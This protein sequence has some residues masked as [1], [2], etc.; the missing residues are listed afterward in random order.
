MAQGFT[1]T[2]AFS[3]FIDCV[4]EEETGRVSFAIKEVANMALAGGSD[5]LPITSASPGS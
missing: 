1:F 3:F 5:S 2:L 4:S